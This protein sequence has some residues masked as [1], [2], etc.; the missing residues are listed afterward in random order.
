MLKYED[1]RDIM[2]DEK[3]NNWK[4]MDMRKGML[5]IESDTQIDLDESLEKL[6]SKIE[7]F[8]QGYDKVFIIANGTQVGKIQNWKGAR[9][10][11]CIINE[12]LVNQGTQ[13]GGMGVATTQMVNSGYLHPTVVQMQMDLKDKLHD[14]EMNAMQARSEFSDKTE[15]D[16]LLPSRYQ[17]VLFC[18]LMGMDGGDFAAIAKLSGPGRES[19]GMPASTRTTNPVK[20]VT[21]GDSGAPATAPQVETTAPATGEKQLTPEEQ[22]FLGTYTPEVAKEIDGLLGVISTKVDAKKFLYLMQ[23]IDKS[24]SIVDTAINLLTQNK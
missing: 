21:S 2:S 8:K 15:I 20:L 17:D 6:D 9:K 13:M 1:V 4:V 11:R 10:L 16:K 12:A 22:A 14:M 7:T 23:M 19:A 24:P 5:S 3:L 18:K